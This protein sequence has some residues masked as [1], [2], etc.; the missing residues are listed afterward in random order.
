MNIV[1]L[2][3]QLFPIQLWIKRG[4]ECNIKRKVPIAGGM[5]TFTLQKTPSPVPSV[6]TVEWKG[7]AQSF[8]DKSLNKLYRKPRFRDDLVWNGKT[9]RSS[10]HRARLVCNG[11]KKF[12]VPVTNMNRDTINGKHVRVKPDSTSLTLLEG[13]S[14]VA[15]SDH[16]PKNST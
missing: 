1:S 3:N 4:K 5:P 6:V 7:A 10:R 16:N 8:H 9:T 2:V 12:I 15:F 11:I 14:S 13:L